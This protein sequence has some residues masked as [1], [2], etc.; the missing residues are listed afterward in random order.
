VVNLCG[1]ELSSAHQIDPVVRA[2][3]CF[4][5]GVDGLVVGPVELPCWTTGGG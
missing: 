2:L 4:V 3:D 5:G 1:L